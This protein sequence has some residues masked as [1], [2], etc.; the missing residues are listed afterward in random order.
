MT[1]DEDMRAVMTGTGPARI[2]DPGDEWECLL[3]AL[4]LEVER[5]EVMLG[6]ERSWS[7]RREALM[8]RWTTPSPEGPLPE[9]LR[10]RAVQLLHRQAAAVSRL[11]ECSS[12][13]RRHVAVLEAQAGARGPEVAVWVDATA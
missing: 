13:N 6:G 7:P 8:P 4:E 12:A 2:G 11:Q 9:R 10:E 3:D 1:H 5:A